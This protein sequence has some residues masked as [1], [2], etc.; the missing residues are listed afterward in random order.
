MGRNNNGSSFEPR[1]KTKNNDASSSDDGHLYPHGI[2]KCSGTYYVATIVEPPPI[3]S[4]MLRVERRVEH[5]EG[6]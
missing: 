4:V 5:G 6:V 1:K 3:P 2:R